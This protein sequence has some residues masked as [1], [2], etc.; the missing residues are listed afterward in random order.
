MTNGRSNRGKTLRS[1]NCE[2]ARF[3]SFIFPL[4]AEL[5]VVENFEQYQRTVIIRY[6]QNEM[7]NGCSKRKK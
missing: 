6:R 7:T 4:Q 3:Q 5:C 1:E 2:Q